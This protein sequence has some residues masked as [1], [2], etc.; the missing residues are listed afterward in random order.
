MLLDYFLMELSPA[1]RRVISEDSNSDDIEDAISG[2]LKQGEALASTLTTT[3]DVK[4]I[5]T[6]LYAK[7]H[8]YYMLGFIDTG[9]RYS[10]QLRQCLDRYDPEN[11][12][13]HTFSVTSDDQIFTD[14]ELGKWF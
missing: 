1:A 2:F 3:D 8:T 9:D 14:T 12:V 11:V 6:V 4:E 13:Q 7:T 5:I 10:S